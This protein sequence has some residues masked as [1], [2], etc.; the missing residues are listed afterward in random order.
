MRFRLLLP[1]LVAA[2]FL[3][4]GCSDLLVLLPPPD[5]TATANGGGGG[6]AARTLT[7]QGVFHRATSARPVE[8]VVWNVPPGNYRRLRLAVSVT[9][10]GW[11][12][13]RPAGTHNIFWL[14]R[15]RNRDLF[16]YANL[17][18]RNQVFIRYGI[19]MGQG[20]KPR[21]TSGGN[22][23]KGKTYRFEYV[24]DAAARQVEMTVTQGGRRI[25]HLNGRAD[26]SVIRVGANDRFV[27]DFG[28]T[29][30]SN[31][32]EPASLGWEWRDLSVEIE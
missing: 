5:G 7:R 2:A 19:G 4:G 16:G 26:Q 15:N 27:M 29:G 22:F 18:N 21:L 14:A 25:S 6:P 11:A 9:H 28:F 17:R 31:A 3:V 24:Y 23:Q 10:G 13:A 8:R 32:N 30:R 1:A 12:A 20:Q